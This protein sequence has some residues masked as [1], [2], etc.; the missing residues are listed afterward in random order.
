[1]MSEEVRRLR[2]LLDAVPMM[3]SYWD[4][5]LTNRFA[6]EAF[7]DCFGM[8]PT[9]MYGRGLPEVLGANLYRL[10]R[11]HLDGVL[12]GEKQVFERTLVDAHGSTRFV[13]GTYVPEIVDGQVTGFYEQLADLTSRVAA[14]HH[15]DDALRLLQVSCEDA[16]IGLSIV[17]TNIRAIYVNPAFCEMFGTTADEVIGTNLRDYVHPADLDTVEADF[18]AL[19]NEAQAHVATELR[20]VRPDGTT[21]WL[22]RNAVMV[23]GTHGTDDLIIG[24]FQDVTARKLA[25]AEL[26]RL[27]VTD[28]LTGLLNRQAFVDSVERQKDSKP[29]SPVGI[30]FVDLDGFKGVNDEHGHAVGDAVLVRFAERLARIVTAPDAVYRL[31]GDEFVVLSTTAAT[32][33]HVEELAELLRDELG[34]TYDAGGVPVRLGASV[35]ST[36]GP[37]GDIEQLLRNADAR[38]YTNKA[39]R[40]GDAE[41]V[42]RA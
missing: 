6:N 38:M 31:G 39:R 17:D 32:E 3:V 12:A 8:T 16:P 27:A 33:S 40:R 23:P 14:E 36:W 30:V 24:Q 37:T 10:T 35:G 18:D 21:M 9:E 2:L 26:A 29:S 19:K 15:R 28:P 7:A 41:S 20:Y 4:R 13:E 42:E 34:G 22:Q 11:P 1:M 25:E 5:D